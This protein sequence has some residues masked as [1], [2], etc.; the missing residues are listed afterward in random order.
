MNVYFFG[1]KA[2]E[3]PFTLQEKK[4]KLK[5]L[6]KGDKFPTS[7]MFIKGIL[8]KN[9]SILNNFQVVYQDQI[10][11]LLE[12]PM[13]ENLNSEVPFHKITQIKYYGSIIW[14]RNKRYHKTDYE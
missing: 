6:K 9:K 5:K 10:L 13:L 8:S 4:P 14:D 12:V 11:R 2:I 7:D 3:I 1:Y